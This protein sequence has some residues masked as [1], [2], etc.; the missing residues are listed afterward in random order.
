MTSCLLFCKLSPARKGLYPYSF[1]PHSVKNRLLLA[2]E[3]EILKE[4]PPLR[5]IIH[6]KTVNMSYCLSFFS[7]SL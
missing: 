1:A 6:R 2:T 7:L 3:T 5:C 4:L